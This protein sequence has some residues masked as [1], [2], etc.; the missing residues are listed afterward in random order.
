MPDASKLVKP[1]LLHS[2]RVGVS[3]Y[4]Y[5]YSEKI[6]VAGFLHD[7]VEDADITI[8]EIENKFGIEIARL[9][10]V[11]TKDSTIQDE[12]EKADRLINKL[13]VFGVDALIIKA[14]DLLDNLILYK[15][16]NDEKAINK[17]M[18]MSVNLLKNK[19]RSLDG[20]LFDNLSR[21][22]NFVG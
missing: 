12:I 21:E 22:I 15:K 10:E 7:L 2:I 11:E 16:R 19:P 9:V 3:L 14:A 17:L 20:E 6:V 18:R 1:T 13:L 4:S 5:G 8:E